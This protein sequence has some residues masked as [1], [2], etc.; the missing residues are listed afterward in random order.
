MKL[1]NWNLFEIIWLTVFSMV[2][3]VLS[4][5]WEDNIF[6]FSV[7][8]SGVFCVVLAA[9]GSIWTYYY[10]MYNSIAYAWLSYQNGLY[11]ETMLNILFF[12]PMNIV[13]WWAWR[14]KMKDKTVIMKKMDWKGLLLM[15]TLCAVG[16][17]TY[18]Y[19]LSTLDGQNTPYIDAFTNSASIIATVVMTLRYREQ[20]ILYFCINFV[21]IIMWVYRFV[22]GNSNAA[23]M[24]VMWSAY[25]VNSVYG[26]YVWHKG[27]K[28]NGID[29]QVVTSV[30]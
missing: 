1:K 24:V 23:T 28:V 19:W 8:I 3:I 5:V 26:F 10:G 14:R 9:K 16:T 2:A 13:G 15:I 11:G 27:S 17:Y 30:S 7:F 6:G 12:V 25:L 4:V 22:D 29:D 21:S 20:W 18:G